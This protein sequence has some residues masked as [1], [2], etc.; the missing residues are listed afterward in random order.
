M[1]WKWKWILYLYIMTVS[2]AVD[3]LWIFT[4]KIFCP[5][6]LI[7]VFLNANDVTQVSQMLIIFAHNFIIVL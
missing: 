1:W 3:E 7:F 4:A 6:K 2:R 5:N